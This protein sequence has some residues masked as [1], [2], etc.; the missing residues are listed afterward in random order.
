MNL[1]QRMGRAIVAGLGVALIAATPAHAL[2]SFDIVINPNVSLQANA[3]ALAAFERAAARWEAFIADPITV[4]INAGLSNLGS[5]ILGQA[6]STLTIRNYTSVRN[7]MVADAADELNDPDDFD[8]TLAQSL[9]TAANFNATLPAGVLLS[10][11][12]S[13]NT[14]L[15]RAMGLF[16]PAS[17]DATITFNTQFSFDYD[18]SDGIDAGTWDFETV[19]AHEIGHALGFTSVVDDINR[20]LTSISPRPLDLFRFTEGGANDPDSVSDFATFTRD[21]RPNVEVN[22]DIITDEWRMS[23]GVTGGTFGGDGRQASHWKDGSL[24]GN[25]IGMMDPT[26]A[27]QQVFP[28]SIADLRALDLIGYEIV[29]LL[30]G[31]YNNDG[32]VDQIDLDLVL[33]TWGDSVFDDESPTEQWTNFLTITA[34]IIGQDELAVVLQNWG[35]TTAILEQLTAIAA[36]TG[37]SEDEVLSLIPEPASAFLMIGGI[38]LVLKRRASLA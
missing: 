4:N 9:P 8:D 20:G 14:S 22:T 6:S 15:A 24:T 25:T 32:V 7:A 1:I 11:D 29:G 28:F 3:D 33:D 31:D 30:P 37:L 2:G 21:L 34:P 17:S 23:T 27:A 13:V 35:N 18:N 16:A 38:A 10:G 19:A 12:M 36:A 5:S 26:L